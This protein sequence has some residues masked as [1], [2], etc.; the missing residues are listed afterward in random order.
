MNRIRTTALAALAAAS[1]C[2]P[3]SASIPHTVTEGETLWSIASANGLTPAVW[4]GAAVVALGAVAAFA[5]KRRPQREAVAL[6]PA[7]EAAA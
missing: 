4:V 1:V 6:E 7:F 3:A 5:I 2:A